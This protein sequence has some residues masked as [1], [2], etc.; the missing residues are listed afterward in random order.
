MQ[1]NDFH[2]RIDDTSKHLLMYTNYNFKTV[3]KVSRIK[4]NPSQ[5]ERTL[6]FFKLLPK[7]FNS[8]DNCTM[9]V[10]VEKKST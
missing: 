1:K 2:D 9:L 7:K 3:A 10:S 5:Y 8:P 6:F 4:K